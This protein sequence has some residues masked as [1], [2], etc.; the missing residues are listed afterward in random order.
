MNLR[1][2]RFPDRRVIAGIAAGVLITVI[3]VS[4]VTAA[5]PSPSGPSTS[6]GTSS[7]VGPNGRAAVGTPLARGRLGDGVRLGALRRAV[8]RNFRVDV[9]ATGKDGTRNLLYVRGTLDVGPGSVT[10]TLPDKSTATFGVDA[11]TLVRDNGATV[12]YTDLV[13]GD[14]AIVVG[15]RNQDGSYT[16]KLIRRLPE[17]TGT[18]APPAVATP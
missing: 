13:D 14:P 1:S 11:T 9:T 8:G 6:S 3:G 2:V 18:V 5:S 15:T 17:P 4:A 16:A 12:K 7:G 10:V